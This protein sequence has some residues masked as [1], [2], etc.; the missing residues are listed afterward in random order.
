M[1]VKSRDERN[2]KKWLPT[3][4]NSVLCPP[5]PA[6]PSPATW[7]WCSMPRRVPHRSRAMTRHLTLLCTMISLL[8]VVGLVLQ[9]S[10][11]ART[12]RDWR[13]GG[14]SPPAG[15]ANRWKLGDT[16]T[17]E[18]EWKRSKKV[19]HI[20][21]LRQPVSYWLVSRLISTWG[22]ALVLLGTLALAWSTAAFLSG[23]HAQPAPIG[24]IAPPG[25]TAH[26]ST[27]QAPR[28]WRAFVPSTPHTACVLGR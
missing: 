4:S 11:T 21:V 27:T 25:M 14:R 3:A 15:G 28:C 6:R 2:G 1:W 17:G 20:R 18:R 24:V 12:R 5:L 19:N 16:K 8:L 9:L 7:G 26:A 10:S 13:Y 22:I 23:S